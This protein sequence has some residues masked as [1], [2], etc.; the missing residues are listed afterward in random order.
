MISYKIVKT[1]DE[2]IFEIKG[3]ANAAKSG[4]DIVCAS[5][6]TAIYMTL[7]LL[8]SLTG[9]NTSNA[10]LDEGYSKII[11]SLSDINGFKIL[12]NLE[13]TLKDLEKQFPKNI[14]KIN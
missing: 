8:E 7:N 5:V 14:K 2:Y 4:K 9:Y 13:F 11:Y 12:D 10:I 6:S 1:K 3:H